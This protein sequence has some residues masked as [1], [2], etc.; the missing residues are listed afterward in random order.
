[1]CKKTTSWY[2]S[3]SPLFY[4]MWIMGTLQFGMRTGKETHDLR[5]GYVA[6]RLDDDGLEYLV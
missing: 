3:P 5:W 4:L 6:L 2:A 1:M